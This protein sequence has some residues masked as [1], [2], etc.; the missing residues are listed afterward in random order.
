M[1]FHFCHLRVTLGIKI[2]VYFVNSTHYTSSD[3]RLPRLFLTMTQ[4]KK[5]A[6]LHRSTV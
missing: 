4:N 5:T 6:D 3:H 2:T 1:A